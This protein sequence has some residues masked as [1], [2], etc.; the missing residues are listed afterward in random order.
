MPRF[1][2]ILTSWLITM[3]RAP[4]VGGIAKRFE[5]NRSRVHIDAKVFKGKEAPGPRC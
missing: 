3:L 2:H 4:L 1:S 5:E